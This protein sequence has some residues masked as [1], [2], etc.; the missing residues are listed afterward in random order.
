MEFAPQVYQPGRLVTNRRYARGYAAHVW[1]GRRRSSTS[2][3]YKVYDSGPT[4]VPTL[5]GISLGF[6]AGEFAAI[7]G[8]SSSGKST[9]PHILGR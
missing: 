6:E 3:T 8:P 1:A 9:L 2:R 5:K 4:A 7:M